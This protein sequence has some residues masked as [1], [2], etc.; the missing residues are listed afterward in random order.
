MKILNRTNFA[1]ALSFAIASTAA[2]A[3]IWH[4]ATGVLDLDAAQTKVEFTL[5]DVLHT[6]HGNFHL[7]SGSIRF[8]PATGA[9]SG[10]LVVDAASGES[11]SGGRDKRMH[12]NILESAVFPE[13]TFTPDHFEGR[14]APEGDSEIE[15]HGMFGMHGATHEL[16][17][18]TKVSVAGDQVTAATQFEVPYVQWGLKNPST[19]FLRVGDKVNINQTAVGRLRQ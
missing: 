9:A 15:L 7:K 17:L 18:K 5:N 11:G 4:T 10:A 1:L 12:K 2:G 13:I 6:V 3:A 16:V 8:D 14:L 19:L